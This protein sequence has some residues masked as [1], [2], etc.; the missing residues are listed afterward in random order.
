MFRL[1][2]AATVALASVAHAQQPDSLK[3][4]IYTMHECGPSMIMFME[5]LEYAEEP[6]FEGRNILVAPDGSP[7]VGE[8]FFTVNQT[9]GYWS[10]F[11]VF[12]DGTVCLISYGNAFSPIVD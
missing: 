8:M 1:V 11:T 3:F 5:A 6:L 10:F 12:Q 4:D 9:T 2:Y 7:V